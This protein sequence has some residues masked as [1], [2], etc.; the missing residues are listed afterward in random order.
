MR[1]AF[2]FL[3]AAALA[4]R[5]LADFDDFALRLASAAHATRAR[6]RLAR[7]DFPRRDFAAEHRTGL[8]GRFQPISRSARNAS[9]IA[10]TGVGPSI[11]AS[12]AASERSARTSEM[13]F[14]GRRAF[15]A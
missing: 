1:C 7:V 10:S 13:I 2:F 14:A 12:T 15:A 3:S 4:L 11:T 8:T 5:L 6:A 9:G